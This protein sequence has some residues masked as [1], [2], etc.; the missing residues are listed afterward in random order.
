M[1]VTSGDIQSWKKKI[2]QNVTTRCL[3]QAMKGKEKINIFPNV[4]SFLQK[5][6]QYLTHS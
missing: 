4:L 2:K 1:S 3:R 5:V 6:L